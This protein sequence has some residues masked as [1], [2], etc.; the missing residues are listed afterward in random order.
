MI[1]NNTWA[2]AAPA[3]AD[4]II[5]PIAGRAT[6]AKFEYDDPAL[7]YVEPRV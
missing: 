1:G 4:E 6:K 2:D 5:T 7:N 3:T